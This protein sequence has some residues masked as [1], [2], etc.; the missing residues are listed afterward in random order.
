MAPSINIPISTGSTVDVS[1]IHG[2][3]TTVPTAYVVK[4]QIPG[5]ELLDMPCYSFLIENK[6]NGKKILFD[7][8]LMKAWKEKLP[9]ISA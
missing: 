4:K 6:Q 3:R 8:G 5:H 1:I 7:L 2:G 9:P